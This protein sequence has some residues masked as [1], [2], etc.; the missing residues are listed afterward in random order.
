MYTADLP[1]SPE[2]TTA[3]FANDTAVLPTDSDPTVA[4]QKLQINL[5]AIQ[6]WFK[7]LRFFF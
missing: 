4:S 7:K 3:T 6:I 5:L 2:S 1:T